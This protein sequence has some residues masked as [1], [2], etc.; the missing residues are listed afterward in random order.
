MPA[1]YYIMRLI[2]VYNLKTTQFTDDKTRP[3]YA[4]ASHWRK[5]EATFREKPEWFRK[6]SGFEKIK[7]FCAWAQELDLSWLWIDSYCIDKSSSAELTEAINS[8]FFWYRESAVCL[9][10][11]DDIDAFPPSSG[12]ISASKLAESEWFR[13]GWTLQELLA[14]KTV[15]FRER[16]W[17]DIGAKVSS[18]QPSS[19]I[20]ISVILNKQLSR[21]TH[22]PEEV[23][24]DYSKATSY[25]DDQKFSWAAGRETTRI[26]DQAYCLM[27]IFDVYFPATYGERDRAMVTLKF[28]IHQ[29]SRRDL[30]G[31]FP[32]SS[33][34]VPASS[35]AK[36]DKKGVS[37]TMSTIVT[38]G[39]LIYNIQG[40]SVATIISDSMQ[41]TFSLFSGAVPHFD[42][43]SILSIPHQIVSGLATVSD[44]ARISTLDKFGNVQHG[45]YLSTAATLGILLTV[46]FL[47]WRGR[48]FIVSGMKAV[49]SIAFCAFA[50]TGFFVASMS[51]SIIVLLVTGPMPRAGGQ[52][53]LVVS[54]LGAIL[55]WT[56]YFVSLSISEW[57]TSSGILSAT[58]ATR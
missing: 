8:M 36:E 34:A 56:Y 41:W 16:T 4:I 29:K 17:R 45:L 22:I 58:N 53:L 43:E 52:G 39:L 12:A 13:R 26:E 55:V 20:S 2:N 9:A 40:S 15:L 7:K 32:V 46:L 18:R 21:V 33:A 51:A 50:L 49:F 1:R 54:G 35:P 47:L 3:R 14:P 10:Y 48:S 28:A 24:D 6:K 30:P 11:L 23:L 57:Y 42:E 19:S 25:S 37:I 27:G 44:Q 31:T 38:T 5:D